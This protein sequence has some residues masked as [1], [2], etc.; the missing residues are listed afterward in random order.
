MPWLD[1]CKTAIRTHAYSFTLSFRKAKPINNIEYTNCAAVDQYHAGFHTRSF[2]KMTL[3]KKLLQFVHTGGRLK[4]EIQIYEGSR[5]TRE[6][7]QGRQ[8]H[9][10]ETMSPHFQNV[11]AHRHRMK[12]TEIPTRPKVTNMTSSKTSDWCSHGHHGGFN[13]QLPKEVPEL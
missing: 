13:L 1:S 2:I 5:L 9:L 11:S 6:K 10:H 12:H 7:A 4:C 3:C 8:A